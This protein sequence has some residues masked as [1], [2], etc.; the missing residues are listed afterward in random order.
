LFHSSTGGASWDPTPI[1]GGE[2]WT[3]V[4]H[5]SLNDPVFYAAVPGTGIL[6]AT[7]Q[8][9]SSTGWT[10]LTAIPNV[11]LPATASYDFMQLDL[12]ASSPRCVYALYFMNGQTVGLY[13]TVAPTSKWKEI[14]PTPVSPGGGGPCLAVAPNSPG[15]GMNDL[16]IYGHLAA[17]R[18]TDSG[19]TWTGDNDRFHVDT[20]AISFWPP[21]PTGG[22]IPLAFVGC[23]GGI[24]VSTRYADPHVSTDTAAPHFN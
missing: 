6:M 12:C 9:E 24:A 14:L 11:G 16:L 21:N 23:D 10:N 19:R 20:W 18:S 1:F 5:I 15:D 7:T 2:V 3:L 22:T 17:A 4:A 8:P 13:S